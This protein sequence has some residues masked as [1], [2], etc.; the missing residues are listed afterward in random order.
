MNTGK[1]QDP[2]TLEPSESA[3]SCASGTVNDASIPSQERMPPCSFNP[4]KCQ[5]LK[6]ASIRAR[7]L[8]T[9]ET[10]RKL[11]AEQCRA[12]EH[13]VA[14]VVRKANEKLNEYS[15]CAHDLEQRGRR[16]DAKDW[17]LRCEG[18]DEVLIL[19]AEMFPNV[20]E[21]ESWRSDAR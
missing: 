1:F 16:E 3:G 2:K 14:G 7:E 12:E 17:K 21:L 10:A 9:S 13:L 5:C 4:L 8:L 19:L 11:V 15:L 6:C 18:M 20:A